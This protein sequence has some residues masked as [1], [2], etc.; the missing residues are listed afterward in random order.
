MFNFSFGELLLIGI[1][2]LVFIGPK[3]LPY[4]ARIL[5]RTLNELKNATADLTRSFTDAAQ[6][7]NREVQ[8]LHQQVQIDETHRP[9]PISE[10]HIE[11]VSEAPPP[12]DPGATKIDLA[13][14]HRDQLAKLEAEKSKVQQL[15]EQPSADG[16]KKS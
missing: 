14:Y 6:D 15:A 8:N 5:G 13:Q 10:G 2:A 7:L 1:L 12:E 3:D 16:S 4:V 9:D 11:H